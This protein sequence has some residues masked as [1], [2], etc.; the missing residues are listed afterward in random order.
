[1]RKIF[2]IAPEAGRHSLQRREFCLS[3][4]AVAL[5][6]PMLA[7]AEQTP[8]PARLGFLRQAGPHEGQL[9][10]LRDGLRRA[11]YVDGQDI[12]IEA[13]YA[14]GIYERLPALAAE[15]AHAKVDVILVDGP[16]AARACKETT[17][18]IPIVFTLEVDPVVDGL[19]DS[20]ARPGGRFTGLTMAVGYGIAAKQIEL[21]KD[22]AG[23]LSRVAVLNNPSNPP[24]LPYL[25]ETEQTAAALGLQV[26]TFEVRGA[27]E[28]PS[29]FTAAAEWHADGLITL[30]D[31]L[32]FSQ[33][34]QISQ[35]AL[36]HRMPGVY[37]E[38]EF[39]VAGGLASY[40]P[41]L[42]D[43]FRRSASYV[44]KILKGTSP[45]DLP[46]EQPTKFELIVNLKTAKAL[47]L[48]L[49]GNVIARADEVV[50]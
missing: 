10:A 6:W 27:D 43:L 9:E 26:R 22:I 36:T 47:G 20:L 35:L 11:G 31:G 33:R 34:E 32:L 19:A 16:A 17:G 48:T 30:A 49:P 12:F 14:D 38:A 4:G 1:L 5:A 8:K 44:D 41:N 28:L 46:I 39:V 37:P 29:I 13:R 23:R 3:V 42:P 7:H 24:N 45:A 50:E 40:G 21:L 18:T 2:K 25:R 15:L